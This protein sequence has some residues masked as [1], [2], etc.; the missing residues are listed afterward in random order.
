MPEYIVSVE[1]LLKVGQYVHF[2]EGWDEKLADKVF[3]VEAAQ[4]IPFKL[5]LVLESGMA[6]RLVLPEA[7]LYP[8]SSKTLYEI[9]FKMRGENVI[10]YPM[11]PSTEFYNRLEKSGFVPNPQD[12][13]LRYL[14]GYTEEDFR[15]GRLREYTLKDMD[16]I[17][18]LLYNDSP[19]DEHIRLEAVVNRLK[20]K[21]VP[22]DVAKRVL[23]QV[24]YREISHYKVVRW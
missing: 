11:L 3:V 24:R 22:D 21:K 13:V 19:Q 17:V 20:I 6:Y 10:L 7:G 9:L 12:D 2:S 5:W 1:P 4:Q 16:T 14:G 18:Y 23:E 8:D 15:E